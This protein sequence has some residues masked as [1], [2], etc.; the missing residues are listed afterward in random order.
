MDYTQRRKEQAQRTE[1]AILSTA[2]ALMR[3]DGFEAVTVR[4][5]CKKA[6]ITTGAFYHHFRSKEELF[7]KGFKPLDR[8]IAQALENQQ[9]E[10]P[11]QRLEIVLRNY[12]RFMEECGELAA[13]YY[14]RRLA[15]PDMVSLDATRNILRVMI[16]CFKQAKE[17][18]V[19]VL[20]DDAEWT[21]NFCY[22]HFRGVVIDWLLCKR[23]YSLLNKMMDEFA[24]FERMLKGKK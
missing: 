6:G 13:R 23:T 10:D 1:S 16:D 17:Q 20:R 4:D 8:Y 22:R 5:I 15:N 19:M 14:Q 18:G 3:E 2:L 21:A 12:A 7:D 11:A 9:S 24:L